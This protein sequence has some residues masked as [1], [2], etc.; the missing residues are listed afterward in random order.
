MI[1]ICMS[2]LEGYSIC[3]YSDIGKQ[4]VWDK[5]SCLISK[6]ELLVSY[7]A[8]F[9]HKVHVVFSGVEGQQTPGLLWK[10][11]ETHISNV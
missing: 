1:H 8:L 3:F 2:C 10:T 11:N 7:W 6:D 4:S 9:F 5:L